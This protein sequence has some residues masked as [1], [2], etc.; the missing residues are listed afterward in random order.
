MIMRLES[1]FRT[2][3]TELIYFRKYQTLEEAKLDIFSYIYTFYNQKSRH[4]T[5]QYKTPNQWEQ[6]YK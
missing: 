3:K 4:S 1:F 5:L 6:N 2:L